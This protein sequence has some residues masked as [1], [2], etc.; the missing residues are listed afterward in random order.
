MSSMSSVACS[1]VA[2]STVSPDEGRKYMTRGLLDEDPSGAGP[3]PTRI[4]NNSRDRSSTTS[5]P[6]RFDG[7]KLSS[8]LRRERSRTSR[9]DFSSSCRMEERSVMGRSLRFEATRLAGR[10]VASGGAL[11]CVGWG[12]GRNGE[13]GAGVEAQGARW[14]VRI[15]S[16]SVMTM[17][18][19]WRAMRKPAF[20]S[21]RTAR[22]WLTPGILGT[23]CLYG[24]LDLTDYHASGI[25]DCHFH[26]L[27]DGIRDVRQGFL[28]RRPLGRTTRKAWN[29]DG[30]S[31]FG[32]FKR[33]PAFHRP[34]PGSSRSEAVNER[35]NLALSGVGR[36]V[37]PLI[38]QPEATR[39]SRPGGPCTA[40]SSGNM[41][42]G[43]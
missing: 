11:L 6:R 15:R 33:Y 27:A 9:R 36:A 35:F 10:V 14:F 34:P 19:P 26:V 1:P 18:L 22:R 32:L 23:A 24:D 13:E 43:F 8:G 40:T 38:R 37:H 4:L 31:L 3:P 17:C 2:A 16:P 29:P 20:S 5:R 28:F 7:R 30:E 42:V 41:G 12:E 25:L 21:A 39:R